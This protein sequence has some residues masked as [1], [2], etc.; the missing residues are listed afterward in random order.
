MWRKF[1]IFVLTPKIHPMRRI[2]TLALG[3]L[4]CLLVS[5]K[6]KNGAKTPVSGIEMPDVQLH[7]TAG[8]TINLSDIHGQ[9]I[10]YDF[11]A[12]W[13]RPCMGEMNPTKQLQ[14]K[15]GNNKVTWVFISFDKD[16]KAWKQAVKSSGVK[17]IHLIAGE[18]AISQFKN[19]LSIYSIP[20]NI[21]ANN[22]LK[23][24]RYDAPHPSEGIYDKLEKTIERYGNSPD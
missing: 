18:G 8:N 4:L 12:S 23:I 14:E 15:I 9:L 21:W 11:W 24:V 22:D 2:T 16:V 20:F 7:D 13:C 10:Y 19:E 17:G 5:F 1:C 6:A 3:L